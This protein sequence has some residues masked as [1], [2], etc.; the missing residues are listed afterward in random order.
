ML[1]SDPKPKL[2]KNS[3]L[4]LFHASVITLAFFCGC[5]DIVL[6]HVYSSLRKILALKLLLL[7]PCGFAGNSCYLKITDSSF[8]RFFF[9]LWGT[10]GVVCGFGFSFSLFSKKSCIEYTEACVLEHLPVLG[11]VCVQYNFP[12]WSLSN[13]IETVV[14]L[15]EFLIYKSSY[16]PVTQFSQSFCALYGSALLN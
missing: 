6:I 8:L 15:D 9:P 7:L 12:K 14:V 10:W 2:T 4:T 1:A 16:W 5:M 3:L 13:D 11:C